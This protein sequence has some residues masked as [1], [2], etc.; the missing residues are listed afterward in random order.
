MGQINL[1]EHRFALRK[2]GNTSDE[3]EANQ[4]EL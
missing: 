3:D 4:P 2:T 1:L